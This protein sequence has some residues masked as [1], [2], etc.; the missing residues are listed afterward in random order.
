MVKFVQRVHSAGRRFSVLA[1][2]LV[3]QMVPFASLAAARFSEGRV[4]L[5][6]GIGTAQPN[7]RLRQCTVQEYSFLVR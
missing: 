5:H 1:T 6:Q 2:I 7:Q 3:G 4:W